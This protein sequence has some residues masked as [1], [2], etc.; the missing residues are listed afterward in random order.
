M[1]REMAVNLNWQMNQIALLVLVGI[2]AALLLLLFV[3]SALFFLLAVKS[4]RKLHDAMFESVLR[5]PMLFFD[6]NPV[7]EF[8]FFLN[9]STFREQLLIGLKFKYCVHM[10]YLPLGRILNRFA[11]DLGCVDDI[12]PT[13]LFD[14]HSV[15]FALFQTTNS[16]LL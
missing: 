5:A 8:C 13:T 9:I 2:T 12:L 14:V 11:G 6:R 3:R 16:M 15:T 1:V 10:F 4:S 7:G